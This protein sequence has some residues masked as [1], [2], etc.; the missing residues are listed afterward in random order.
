MSLRIRQSLVWETRKPISDAWYSSPAFILMNSRWRLELKY[1]LLSNEQHPIYEISMR[2]CGYPV[3][4]QSFSPFEVKVFFEDRRK[5]VQMHLCNLIVSSRHEILCRTS[6]NS[7]HRKLPGLALYDDINVVCIFT[8]STGLK[9]HL[10]R[11]NGEYIFF[12]DKNFS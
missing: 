10:M 2:Y 7:I 1:Y 11:E 5:N 12:L 9:L 6:L 3:A 4:K 8:P